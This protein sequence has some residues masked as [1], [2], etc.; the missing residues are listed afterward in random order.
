MSVH[1]ISNVN[2]YRLSTQI[3]E[4]ENSLIYQ[5]VRQQDH[6]PVI[7]KLLKHDYPTPT[8]LTR[9]K[10]EYDIIRSLNLSGIIQA[11]A[12]E[13]YQSNLILVLEDFGGISLKQ[14]LIQNQTE[15]QKMSLSVFLP[16]AIQ[17][18]ETLGRIHA[19]NVIHKDINPANILFN[20][21]TEQV[22]IIDFGIASI[23][24]RETPTLRNPNVLEGTLPYISPEQTGRMNRSLDYR[25]D[26]YSLGVT[27]YELLTGELPFPTRD[28]L[29][30][31]HCHIAKQA[32]PVHQQHGGEHCPKALAD[33]VIK[34]MCKT[35][36][37][38]YQS[39]WGLK[40]DLEQCWSQLQQTGIMTEFVLGTQ[41]IADRF[42]IPQKLYGREAE[43]SRLLAAFDRIIRP[44]NSLSTGVE[45]MLVTGHSGIGK[46][47]LVAEVHKP[48]TVSRGYFIA[49]KFDQFQR[50][51]PYSAIVAAFQDLVRQLLTET[52][53]QLQRWREK[54]LA[55]VGTNGQIIVEVIP[56]IE[57]IIG[58]QTALSEL[59][60]TESQNRFNLVFGNFIR[61]FCSAEHPLVIFLDDLQWADAATLKLIEL[62]LQD[63]KTQHLFLIGA[64]RNNEV[65]ATHALVLMREELKR[66]GIIAEEI[67]LTCL[68]LNQISQLIADTLHTETNMVEPLAKLVMQK[69]EGNPFF[70]NEFLKTLYTEGL[71]TFNSNSLLWQWDL[72]QIE[73]IGITNN[74]VELMIGK[75][76]KLPDSTQQMLRL[77]ACIGAEFNL[78]TLSTICERPEK[79]V[80]LDLKPAL[81]S[82]LITSRSG[83]DEQLLIQQYQFGHD[84]VQQAAYSLIETS[85]KQAI[86]LRIGRLLLYKTNIE[87]LGETIF[88]I[89]DHLNLGIDLVFNQSERNEIAR[90]NLMAG[91][92]AKTA[93]AYD[94]AVQ[95]LKTGLS[96]LDEQ[97]WR[98]QYALTL[99]LHQTAVE[100]EYLNANFQQ[101]EHLADIIL[102]NAETKIDQ[103]SSY[104]L[105]VQLYTAQNLPMAALTTG[106]QAVERL[107]V[108]LA[109]DEQSEVELP[110]LAALEMFPDMTDTAQLAVMRIL[111][112]ICPAAYFAR[113]ELLLSI[114]LT[115]IQ[116]TLQQGYSSLAAYAY[117]WYAA[118]CSAQGKIDTGYHAGQLA[119]K[120]VDKFHAKELK[121]K[122]INL[123]C[124][125]VRHWKEPAR[126]S[127]S[128]LQEG[129]QSGLDTGDNEYACYCI[130]DY[131][132]HLFL[133]GEPL[134]QVVS[135]MAQSHELLLRL[136]QDYSIYQ[137]NIWRQV[138][139][140]LLGQAE[141]RSRLLGDCFNEDEMIP[142][143]EAANNRTLLCIV[144]L[145]KLELAY[146]FKD[147]NQARSH[148]VTAATYL[149]AVMGFM[150][151]AVH[152]FYESLTLLA[153][154]WTDQAD[155]LHQVESNQAQMQQW[156]NHAPANFQ[157]KYDLVA[158]EQARVLGISWQAAKHY[159]QAILGAR[160]NGFLQEAALASELA[161]SFYLSCQM[162]TIAQTY[163][164]N[165]YSAYMGWQAHAKIE[166]LE[167]RYPHWLF[168][169][170]ANRIPTTTTRIE[171]GTNSGRLALDLATVLK[172]S[173]AIS[174]EIVLEQLLQTLM[175][176]LIEN[177]GAQTGYLILESQAQL[178]I[179]ASGNVDLDEVT[180][181]QSLAVNSNTAASYLCKTIVYYVA[182]TRE[183]LVLNDASSE[184]KFVNDPYVLQY[185]PKS[186]LCVPLIDQG[187]LI[188]I[189]YLENNLITGAF[190]PDRVEILKILSAQAAISI[191]NARLYQTLEDKVKERT[192][193][194][195]QANQEI[196][197]LNTRLAAENI[198][199]SAEL[200]VA[201][202]LQQMVLPKQSELEAITELDIAGFMEPATKVGGDYYDV[203]QQNGK[204]KIGIG[205][206]T[207][208]GLESGVLMIMVQTAVRTLL[209]IEE[210]DPTKIL[211]A[212]NQV[213]YQNV[214]RMGSYRNL[215]LSLL[216]YQ[217]GQLHLSG[218]HEEV[219]VVRS[220]GQV[221]RIDTIDLG[222]P[223]G[224][225]PEI[226][227]FVA[228][229]PIPLNPGDGVVLYTD[230][231]TEAEGLD[232]Q[233]YG[234]ERLIK[235]IQTNWQHS[236]R[237][238][239]RIV[240]EDVR[241]HI[242]EKP[243]R[244]DITL[245]VLKKK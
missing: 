86:H 31:I 9:Y 84:R 188:S 2:G 221:E 132:V 173:Q 223:L 14:W 150:Y 35:A 185:Q 183:N 99:N 88:D 23:F 95:Y 25:T 37:G 236:A 197:A 159:E 205:D 239:S 225:I 133:T 81:Q 28:A 242:S 1:K 140:N 128:A 151:V 240:V 184:G 13:D 165:A 195:A 172:A 48:I 235:V 105:K 187:K 109:T 22:K 115:M 100:A 145:A 46:S 26:F 230:G 227:D 8:T 5:G 120:L 174:G 12:L 80:F 58:K 181:L 141:N 238:I 50:N 62:M 219:L 222:F 216:E 107:G 106:L 89:V 218:Q 54:L 171:T 155:I 6:L 244:D 189:L 90:L 97:S 124:A 49:G 72:A 207:G 170:S 129:I 102:Q 87:N 243:L 198:R 76:K 208:H 55:A 166:E 213:I 61:A 164:Q 38:R 101:A 21:K 57:L 11:Y 110:S 149:E 160:T 75:L 202:Q 177:A 179:E 94:A 83:L 192:A 93:T 154:S 180:V 104:E 178:L 148:A 67:T 27:F 45:L 175:K 139:L 231:I 18:A 224:I 47:T 144:Y 98:T 73:A 122:V 191:E 241:S 167:A 136:K 161:A 211:N 10:Q 206:V 41:D 121:A 214:Q 85:E 64:Y 163:L 77:A 116:L 70:V 19:A 147:Y 212:I 233:L 153:Q 114:V 226:A 40:A 53:E 123:F 7:L 194:L 82:S 210:H 138:S 143:L 117:V 15:Q 103:A 17:I 127:I 4:S 59:G 16:I 201:K 229:T 79:A 245:V 42:Q 24:T 220:D 43:V 69:T 137:T 156:A 228:Q 217:N 78:A 152:N 65:S 196:T 168:N 186:I 135:S 32:I 157:H 182:R 71:L 176:I 74:V 118:I 126:N 146:W 91:Q 232:R 204:V 142:H 3:Y 33:I 134:E 199:M 234:L 44:Q 200:D 125:L 203:F 131:C 190:T 193:Q 96:L 39:A 60:A 92:K 20:P 169:G 130:K 29:E 113:P 111:M 112:S 30:L 56:Q 158:A 52:E 36:E 209:A 162:E 34:L 108:V 68:T 119:L 63:S 237:E 215:T 51:V 66:V